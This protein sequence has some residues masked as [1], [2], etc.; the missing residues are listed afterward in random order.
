MIIKIVA[1]DKVFSSVHVPCKNHMIWRARLRL[2]QEVVSR[3]VLKIFSPPGPVPMYGI[4]K[5]DEKIGW[6]FTHG[7]TEDIN[8]LLESEGS[9]GFYILNLDEMKK[10][11]KWRGEKGW[12]EIRESKPL[13]E[14]S[15]ADSSV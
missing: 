11:Y 7:P 2:V 9:F 6:V 1:D 8:D 13:Q 12:R 15:E 10:L 3:E 14:V 5:K 4:G